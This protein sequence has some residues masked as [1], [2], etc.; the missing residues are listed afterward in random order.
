[1]N[2]MVET[3]DRPAFQSSEITSMIRGGGVDVEIAAPAT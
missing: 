1:M 3:H 2:A